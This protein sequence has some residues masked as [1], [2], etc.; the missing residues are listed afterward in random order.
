[1]DAESVRE[2]DS[3]SDSD[4]DTADS[5]ECRRPS[6]TGHVWYECLA[7]SPQRIIG[8]LLEHSFWFK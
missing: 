1:M 6:C 3:D 5:G 8:A 2:N 7:M 4:S